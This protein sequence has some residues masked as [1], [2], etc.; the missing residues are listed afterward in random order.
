MSHLN[1][2][3]SI[4]ICH[5]KIPILGEFTEIKRNKIHW[6]EI[7]QSNKLFYDCWRAWNV[8]QQFLLH[9]LIVSSETK[10]S[11]QSVFHTSIFFFVGMFYYI[12]EMYISC[13]KGRYYCKEFFFTSSFPFLQLFRLSKRNKTHTQIAR[14]NFILASRDTQKKTR[15]IKE[16]KKK[17]SG[18]SSTRGK[19]AIKIDIGCVYIAIDT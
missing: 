6:A 16:N 19:I 10:H 7:V 14:I 3:L 9:P 1:F 18:M 2:E 13:W 8:L 4:L 12:L 15:K 17:K 5:L 11:I